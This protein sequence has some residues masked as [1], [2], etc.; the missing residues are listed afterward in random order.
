MTEKK[1][2]IHK[3]TNK[4]PHITINL[5]KYCIKLNI[6]D[7]PPATGDPSPATDNLPQQYQ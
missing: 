7:R 5:S 6:H 2:I 1:V 3:I 4:S